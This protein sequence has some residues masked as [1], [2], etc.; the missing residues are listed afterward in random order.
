L[1]FEL[2]TVNYLRALAQ[3]TSCFI[4]GFVQYLKTVSGIKNPQ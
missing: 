2:I 3:K 4:V 1:N